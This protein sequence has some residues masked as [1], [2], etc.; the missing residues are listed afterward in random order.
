M[1]TIRPNHTEI[2]PVSLLKN[3]LEWGVDETIANEP[4][5][6]FK[7]TDK[8]VSKQFVTETTSSN[9]LIKNKVSSA[10]P[11]ATHQE[12]IIN[13]TEVAAKC[14]TLE[15]L[16]KAI[17]EF[18]G[19]SLKKTASNTV[20]N[21]GNTDSNIMIIGES[22]GGSEDREGKPFVG[23]AGQLLNKMFAAI[24]M[25]REKDFY[26]TNILP[27]RPPGNRK[28]TDTECEICMPFLK[29]HI[30]LFAPKMII[31]VGGT[32]ANVLIGSKKSIT[33]IRGKWQEYSLNDQKI[34]I[35]ALFHPD[36]LIQHPQFKKQTWHDLLDIKAKIKE[37]F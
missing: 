1:N 32:S 24:D 33:K 21:D 13:A 3:Y 16:N 11:L 26:I 7:Q 20:F 22:P 28:P 34:P 37:L 17:L 4:I 19:C 23:E 31:M 25:T 15:E 35:V 27:W 18:D 12:T 30:E 2:D 14:N 5:N 8:I 9:D 6:W 29:R 36:Y 10:P